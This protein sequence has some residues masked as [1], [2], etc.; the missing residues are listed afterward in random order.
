MFGIQFSKERFSFEISLSRSY[1]ASEDKDLSRMRDI[2]PIGVEVA[3][4]KKGRVIPPASV[5]L[6]AVGHPFVP[7][8]PILLQAHRTRDGAGEGPTADAP[9]LLL[10]LSV[11]VRP[12]TADLTP[13]ILP[14][15]LG[16]DRSRDRPVNVQ[17]QGDFVLS[18]SITESVT[19]SEIKKSM[20]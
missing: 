14:E 17:E 8:V 15:V 7:G 13:H 18:K 5:P 10:S 3:C 11:L 1:S 2:A 9:R 20:V 12:H 19:T 16:I 4:Q 6:A